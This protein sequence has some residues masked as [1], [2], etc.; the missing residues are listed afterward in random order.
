VNTIARSKRP[1]LAADEEVEDAEVVHAIA[2]GAT[3]DIV[4][5]PQNAVSDSAH[6]AAAAT[7]VIQ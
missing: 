6:F 5:V 1:Y 7:N 4:L 2:P 3:L